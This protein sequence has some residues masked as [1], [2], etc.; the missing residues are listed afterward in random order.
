MLIDWKWVSFSREN[1]FRIFHQQFHIYS[2][3]ID[4]LST[5]NTDLEKQ[6]ENLNSFYSER[7]EFQNKIEELENVIENLNK[8][9]GSTSTNTKEKEKAITNINQKLSKMSRTKAMINDCLSEASGSI[10]AALVIFCQF[11]KEKLDFSIIY[12]FSGIIRR[13]WRGRRQS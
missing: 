8:K 10:R 1:N 5:K 13:I 2:Q 4:D 7:R 12:N 9:L 11:G 3:V 6:L